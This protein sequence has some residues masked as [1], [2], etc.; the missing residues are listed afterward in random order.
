MKPTGL[1]KPYA[2]RPWRLNP[3]SGGKAMIVSLLIPM[4]V[5]VVVAGANAIRWVQESVSTN[6]GPEPYQELFQRLDASIE[7]LSGRNVADSTSL[8]WLW[9]KAEQ[10]NRIRTLEAVNTP[11]PDPV[12]T[13]IP[14][15]L[16]L[17]L[18]AE[19]EGI[20]F[21]RGK[22]CAYVNSKLLYVN[23]QQ[24]GWTVT[25]IDEDS[26]TFENGKGGSLVL[27][28]DETLRERYPTYNRRQGKWR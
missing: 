6:P 23:D 5:S 4:V 7:G 24:D 19:L 8:E 16:P 11:E 21:R 2:N 26:V 20:V 10:E 22:A 25:A 28:I 15:R 12:V 17:E 3:S 27:N 1:T 18:E 9:L 13:P 14:E